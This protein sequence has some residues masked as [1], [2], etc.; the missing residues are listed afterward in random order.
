MAPIQLYIRVKTEFVLLAGDL[1]W[2][3]GWVNLERAIRLLTQVLIKRTSQGITFVIW[4]PRDVSTG[5]IR[6]E[7]AGNYLTNPIYL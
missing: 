4:W 1:D 2:V 3:G 6:I 5:Y 7:S